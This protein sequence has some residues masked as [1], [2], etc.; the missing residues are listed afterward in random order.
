MRAVRKEQRDI[1]SSLRRFEAKDGRA[2]EELE[3][4]IS[5]A[6]SLRRRDWKSSKG[7]NHPAAVFGGWLRRENRS[8]RYRRI[9]LTVRWERIRTIFRCRRHGKRKRN[10]H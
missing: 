2:I 6:V 4:R 8:T 9:I 5:A 3:E 10:R 7:A 1:L